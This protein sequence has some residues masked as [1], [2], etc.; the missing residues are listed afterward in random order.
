MFVSGSW[1]L[2]KQQE[3]ERFLNLLKERLEQ[4]SDLV[5]VDTNGNI[6]QTV[7]ATVGVSV[8]SYTFD[9]NAS[10][11]VLTETQRILHFVICKPALRDEHGLLL[12]NTLLAESDPDH[13]HLM[14]LRFYS[15]ASGT[16]PVLHS[17]TVAFNPLGGPVLSQNRFDS[18]PENYGLGGSPYQFVLTDVHKIKVREIDGSNQLIEISLKLAHPNPRYGAVISQSIVAY[19]SV[20]V[21]GM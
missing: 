4:A 9:S 16:D 18:A 1:R 3:T 8:G 12:Y 21:G 10:G 13:S 5:D 15:T 19:P 20:S 2:Q 14:R 6:T 11:T 17:P 7:A